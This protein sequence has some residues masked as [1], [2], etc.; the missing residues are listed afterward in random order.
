MPPFV[1]SSVV[2]GTEIH[3]EWEEPFTWPDHDVLYYEVE[4]NQQG[5]DEETTVMTNDT[6]HIHSS[7][8]GGV[9]EFCQLVTFT[10]IAV[11]DLGGSEPSGSVQLGLPI[12]QCCMT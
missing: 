12:G 6:F 3:L 4:L 9:A 10:V 7:P 5:S 2:D 8:S 1:N 11:S